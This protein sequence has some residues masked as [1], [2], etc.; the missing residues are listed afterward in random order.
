MRF[1]LSGG[2]EY[3]KDEG[4]D[5]RRTMQAWIEEE[6]GGAVFNPNVESDRLFSTK[7]EG[8]NFRKLKAQDFRHYQEIAREL[9]ELDTEEIAERSDVVL[10]YWD[11]SAQRGAG[12]KGELTIA[13]YFRKPVFMVTST[14]MEAIPG[15]VIG[16][17]TM[18]LPDFDSLKLLLQSRFRDGSLRRS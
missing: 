7:H 5:W 11:D 14:P 6:L 15:W 9:V 2:M 17:V 10:C 12:T 8:V 13:K 1:Y 3:S 4:R 18:I 16:C